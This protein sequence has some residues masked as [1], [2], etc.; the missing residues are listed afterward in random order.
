M[1]SCQ[2]ISPQKIVIEEGGV[3]SAGGLLKGLG[4]KALV[5]IGGSSARKNG[6]LDKLLH[7]LESAGISNAVFEGIPSDPD[8]ATIETGYALCK[9]NGCDLVVGMGGGSVLDTAKAVG[10]LAVNGGRVTDYETSRPP[11]P[12]LPMLAI[13]TTAGTASEVTKMA[14]IT[15]P[16]QKKKMLLN[17]EEILPRIALLD[18]ELTYSMPAK[19]AAATGMDALTHAMEAYLSDKASPLTDLYALKAVGM[20]A[21]NIHGATYNPKNTAAKQEMLIGQMFAGMAFSNT[22]T[23]LVHSMS[24][25]LGVYYGIPHGEANAVLLATVMEYNLPACVARMADMA[26]A[27][28]LSREGGDW[29]LAEALIEH[30]KKI[31]SLLPLRHDLKEMGVRAEDLRPM[32]ESA[33]AAGTTK[34]NPR[35]PTVDEIVALY[36]KLM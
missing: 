21:R 11:K 20:I 32:A 33:F 29:A 36:R 7:S 8:V 27:M 10:L 1:D 14:V 6:S 22:M 24:R 28:G 15:D 16:V 9:Q 34:V 3:S 26:K 13:P 19:I 18:V 23:C 35:K 17:C 12:M 30:L 4:T 31:H 25:P 5:C 2:F